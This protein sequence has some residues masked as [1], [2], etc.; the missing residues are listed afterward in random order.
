MGRKATKY[1][2][3]RK[4]VGKP[5]NREIDR[6]LDKWLQPPNPIDNKG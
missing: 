6:T 2:R 5:T 3:A 4:K 1:T